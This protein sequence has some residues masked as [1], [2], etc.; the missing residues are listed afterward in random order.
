MANTAVISPFPVVPLCRKQQ[1]QP[2]SFSTCSPFA[3]TAQGLFFPV[4]LSCEELLSDPLLALPG[5]E[6]ASSL[7]FINVILL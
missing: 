5:C 6:L 3:A 7:F 2:V 1:Q 4:P